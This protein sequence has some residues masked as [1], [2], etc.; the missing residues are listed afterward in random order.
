M[1]RLA[2]PVRFLPLFSLLACGGR[3][4]SSAGMAAGGNDSG[5]RNAV[6][7]GGGAAGGSEDCSG[8]SDQPGRTVDVRITNNAESALYFGPMTAGSYAPLFEVTDASGKVLTNFS[9][10]PAQCATAMTGDKNVAAIPAAETQ[11]LLP[12]ETAD[13]G[14]RGTVAVTRTLPV[15]C[16]PPGA[17]APLP[18]QQEVVAQ[19]GVYTF[20][21]QAG[22]EVNCPGGEC[23]CLAGISPCFFVG[24]VVSGQ[25]VTAQA[26]LSFDASDALGDTAGGAAPTTLAV[27]I[28]FEP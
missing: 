12:G 21:T 6:S 26:T 14:W 19:S 4:T 2:A 17:S 27:D 28:D 8:Y 16:Q 23:S 10:S 25:V 13:G 7:E 15:A 9:F 22:T 20:S 5:G 24:A 1:R 3:E 18:C 11:R